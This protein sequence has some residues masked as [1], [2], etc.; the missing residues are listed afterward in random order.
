MKKAVGWMEDFD[1]ERA[2]RLVPA[3]FSVPVA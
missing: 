3:E 1:F 2:A